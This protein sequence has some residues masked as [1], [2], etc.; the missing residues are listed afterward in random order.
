MIDLVLTPI[1]RGTS[2]QLRVT[3]SDTFDVATDFTGADL[4]FTIK[5]DVR[6]LD[7]DAVTQL[8]NAVGGGITQSGTRKE[9]AL[10]TADNVGAGLPNYLV[11]L[12]CELKIRLADD[13]E[14]VIGRGTLSLIEA[15]APHD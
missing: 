4:W 5:K 8:T 14:T 1:A 12:V 10:I 3:L 6:D 15:V 11:R 13:F 9:V 2:L 7:V